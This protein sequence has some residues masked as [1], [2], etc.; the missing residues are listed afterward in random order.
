MERHE[1]R[2]S[3]EEETVSQP[4]EETAPEREE[5]TAPEP[6]EG[7]APEDLPGEPGAEGGSRS[8]AADTPPGLPADD[9]SPLGDTDQHSSG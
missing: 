7:T 8:P 4:Q 3:P 9:D 2:P 5:R 6:E 1:D